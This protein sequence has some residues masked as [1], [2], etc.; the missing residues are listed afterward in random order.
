MGIGQSDDLAAC[1]ALASKPE[2]VEALEWAARQAE[3]KLAKR[4]GCPNDDEATKA[5]LRPH[6]A[7]A[8]SF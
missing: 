2:Q 4:V 6:E 3:L 1:K 5:W 7:W 8:R